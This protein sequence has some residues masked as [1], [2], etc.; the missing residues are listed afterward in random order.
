MNVKVKKCNKS[1][2]SLYYIHSLRKITQ[3]LLHFSQIHLYPTKLLIFTQQQLHNKCLNEICFMYKTFV[4]V[5]NAC[6]KCWK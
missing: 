4:I 3:Q 5:C 2:E 1:K 6:T